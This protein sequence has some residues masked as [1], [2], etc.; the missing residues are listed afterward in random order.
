MQRQI[1]ETETASPPVRYRLKARII[2][3]GYPSYTDFANEINI[4]RV[5][6]SKVLN[7]HEFPSPTLQRRMAE[8]LGLS[9][10][11][12]KAML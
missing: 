4:H 3:A 8:E 7:G 6:L 1:L 12:L 5:W 2:G 11:E 9:L 10:K